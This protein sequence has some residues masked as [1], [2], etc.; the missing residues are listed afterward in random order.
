MNFITFPVQSTNLFPAA[1]SKAGSQLLSEW[2][3]KCR[4]TVSTDPNIQYEIG[5]SFTHDKYDYEVSMLKDDS[6][7]DVN[8]YTLRIAPG[9][10]IVNG[11][12]VESL[13]PMSID[14]VEANMQLNAQSRS[15]LKGRLTIGLR[16]YYATNETMAGTLLVENEDD[17]YLGIQ[18]VILPYD[19]FIT[20]RKS[21]DDP[22]KV[23]AH[24]ELAS[25]NFNNNKITYIV[26]NED[27]TKYIPS[28]RLMSIDQ[29][30]SDEYVRKTGLNSKKLYAFAGKGLDPAT[31][32]DTWEDVTDSTM[33]WDATPQR[34]DTKPAL[35]ES[36][37]IAAGNSVFLAAVHKQVQGM[38]KADGVT[39]EYYEPKLIPV[40]V[41]DYS[42][43]T[44]GIVNREF[45]RQIK[46]IAAKVEDYRTN[47]HGKQIMYIETKDS[48]VTLPP[49]N[50][51]WDCGDYILVGEDYTADESSDGVRPPSTL[52]VVL[53]GIVQSIL[54]STTVDNSDEIPASITGTE[55]GL[56]EWSQ[57]NRQ[58]EPDTTDPQFYPEFYDPEQDTVRGIPQ[59]DYFRVK[60]VYSDKTY[61][62]YYY[63]VDTAGKREWSSFVMLTGSIPLATETTI[64]GFLNVSEDITDKGYVY[65]DEYGR[66][67]LLDYALLRQGTLAY[68]L[69][70]DLKLPS[71]IASDEVQ[72]YLDDY[73]NQRIAFP[74]AKQLQ[75]GSPNVINVYINLSAEDTP[76][77]INIADIDSRFNTA[78]CLHIT[79]NA[80][81]TTTINIYDC[82]KIKI[83][84]VIEGTP[85]INV[86]RSCLYYDPQV[87]NFIRQAT[88]SDE[89]FTGFEDLSLW[90][91]MY[92][93]DDPSLV[94]DGMTVSQ[95]DAPIA[96][97]E[98]DYWKESGAEAN[99]NHYLTALKSITFSGK[100]DIVQFGLLVANQSTDNIEQGEKI[101]VG[102]FT[103]PQGSALIYPK[104]CLTQQLKV[105][106]AFVSAYLAEGEW[107]VADTLFSAVTDTYNAYTGDQTIGGNIAFH[108][109]TTVL[110]SVIAETA[111][112]AWETDTFH[113]FYGGSLS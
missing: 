11:H 104:S 85:V 91:E 40:P 92:E 93:A 24:L 109:K 2:N 69:A 68:Q 48:N 56:L 73:V 37:F 16:A 49:I 27:K 82:Q 103:L 102:R 13:A 55:L 28:D 81:A 4:E 113:L 88:R 79:G 26:N 36:Q 44:P 71:G 58:T 31:G 52:Y 50:A 47:L 3:L 18:V 15:P 42:T 97:S 63:V 76:K 29:I 105:S 38:T 30:V 70:E 57:D 45:T 100:G 35:T 17:M 106:G 53:P 90:Y 9:V 107:F 66:L 7:V 60:Y 101:A 25:F 64:G 112:P 86:Y 41:A 46:D 32:L 43:N 78:V 12:Y 22:S 75:S 94:V 95:L 1:N 99:D 108:T 84:N 21:P 62:N 67:R 5:H 23:N 96:S 51:S 98:T 89:N 61:K 34:T 19:E 14:L 74:N 6:G 87:F 65:R 20:P 39:P 54:Y 33:I 77:T 72:T 10:A 83:D 8:S 59:K 80:T 110:P 111:I